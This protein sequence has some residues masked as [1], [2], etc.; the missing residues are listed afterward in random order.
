M[1]ILP[2]GIRPKTLA[3][4]AIPI[5]ALVVT[6]VVLGLGG[7]ELLARKKTPEPEPDPNVIPGRVAETL[8]LD[9]G[10]FGRKG[11]AAAKMTR[12]HQE[13]ALEGWTFHDMELYVE[14][15]DLEGFFVTYV[16]QQ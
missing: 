11:G 4:R 8:Y 16:R 13:K 9:V 7:G 14:N 1:R 6:V 2:R 12:L 3:W 15:G 10:R 5:L